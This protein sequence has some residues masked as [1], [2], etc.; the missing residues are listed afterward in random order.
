M[1]V[2]KSGKLT[3]P[4]IDAAGSPADAA[5]A[6]RASEGSTWIGE[7]GCKVGGIV[8]VEVAGGPSWSSSVDYTSRVHVEIL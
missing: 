2:S 1:T 6:R 4:A 7:V 5:R 8:W 3:S